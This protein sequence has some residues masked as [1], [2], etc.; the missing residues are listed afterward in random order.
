MANVTEIREVVQ[1]LIVERDDK[2]TFV[3]D[4]EKGSKDG[5]YTAEVYVRRPPYG[6]TNQLG[7]SSIDATTF[8]PMLMLVREFPRLDDTDL[9]R[10]RSSVLEAIGSLDLSGKKTS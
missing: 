4:L 8:R 7:P 6:A 10:L 1:T 5:S 3:V 2:L 9:E